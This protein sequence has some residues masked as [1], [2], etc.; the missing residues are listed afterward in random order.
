TAMDAAQLSFAYRMNLA[1]QADGGENLYM[2]ADIDN[3]QYGTGGNAWVDSRLG[4][5]TEGDSGWLTVTLDIGAL[6]TGNHTITLGGFFNQSNRAN[7]DAWIRFDDVVLSN[8][9][10]PSAD[11]G[12]TNILD[13]G[14]GN[15]TLYGSTGTDTLYGGAGDDVLYSGSRAGYTVA[16]AL[17][18]NA[19]VNYNATTGNFYESVNGNTTYDNSVTAAAASTLNGVGGHLATI[20]SGT[21]NAAVLGYINTAG[22]G[23][24]WL[25]GD[26]TGTEDDWYWNAGPEAGTHFSTGSTAEPGQYANWQSGQPNDWGSGQDHF[27]MRSADGLWADFTNTSNDDYVVEWE[28]SDVLGGGS[29]STLNGGDGLD[30]LYGSDGEDHFIFEAASAFNDID[31]IHDFDR[32]QADAI[33]ISD[34]LSGLGVNAGN[35]SQYVDVTLGNGVRV[36]VTGSSSFGAPTQI[37]SFAGSTNVTDEATMLANGTLII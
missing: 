5:V 10:G 36:D 34:V 23:D 15:D 27:Q 35:L 11:D 8:A 4:N 2:Y 33:D 18:E 14:N 20:T 37:A 19:N 22:N 28:G 32:T 17:A 26:D 6:P 3:T 24:S 31:V 12:A 13:G 30:N 9:G 25:G 7:E 16:D 21:E 29:V 1:T